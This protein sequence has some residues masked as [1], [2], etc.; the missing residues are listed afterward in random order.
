M[1]GEQG[2]DPFV[3]EADGRESKGYHGDVPCQ[4]GDD[5]IMGAGHSFQPVQVLEIASQCGLA[6]IV[7]GH[8]SDD[9][10]SPPSC[11]VRTCSP[12]T[13]EA[14][15]VSW[16]TSVPSVTAYIQVPVVSVTVLL[17]HD[18]RRFRL[19]FL[20]SGL[21]CGQPFAKLPVLQFEFHP[22]RIDL[23]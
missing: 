4:S 6:E 19:Q 13:P 12:A 1:L 20:R 2:P 14:P 10:V 17:V 15:S 3:V 22:A 16:P 21:E 9:G 11:T 5:R 18:L 7:Q 23:G 8:R